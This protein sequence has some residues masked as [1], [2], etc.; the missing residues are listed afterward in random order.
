MASTAPLSPSL[1]RTDAA[2]KARINNPPTIHACRVG[3]HSWP[4]TCKREL[5]HCR[6]GVEAGIL[7]RRPIEQGHHGLHGI[8]VRSPLSGLICDKDG[9]RE[10]IRNQAHSAVCGRL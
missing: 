4:L 9:T 2:P 1:R 8:E 6:N 3:G 7:R 5:A 10:Y